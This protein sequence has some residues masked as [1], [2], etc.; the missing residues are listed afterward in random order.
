MQCSAVVAVCRVLSVRRA[1]RCRVYLEAVRGTGYGSSGV[2]TG[3]GWTW[4]STVPVDMV[5]ASLP[6]WP[7]A[8]PER[9]FVGPPVPCCALSTCSLDA[10]V[11][12]LL[13][14]ILSTSNAPTPR[15][16]PGVGILDA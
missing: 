9:G 5:S 8:I 16:T 2:S 1:V 3:P 15:R 10:T 12:V 7:A 11:G 14:C 6:S 13:R 4:F